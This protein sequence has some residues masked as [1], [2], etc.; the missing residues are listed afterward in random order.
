MN[1]QATT[2]RDIVFE[3]ETAGGGSFWAGD[4]LL[5]T[6]TVHTAPERSGRLSVRATE[7]A[8][9]MT[10]TASAQR[11]LYEMTHEGIPAG[12]AEWVHDAPSAWL[13]YEG[14]DYTVTREGLLAA[15][16]EIGGRPLVALRALGGRQRG[17]WALHIEPGIE[18]PLVAFYLFV[19]YDLGAQRI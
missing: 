19:A 9:D 16:S 13:R 12:R 14:R 17:Q 8:F 3:R 2:W 1:T 10:R 6:L 11:Y 4:S 5:A 15:E 7:R 18:L